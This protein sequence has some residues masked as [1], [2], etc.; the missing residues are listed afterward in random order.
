VTHI[1]K[2]TQLIFNPYRNI[3]SLKHN[4][5][6]NRFVVLSV[7]VDYQI[8]LIL[9]LLKLCSLSVENY[10]AKINDLYNLYL[11]FLW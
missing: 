3:M 8:W 10:A 2:L 5:F 9:I 4:F 1:G 6:L 11:L 7:K